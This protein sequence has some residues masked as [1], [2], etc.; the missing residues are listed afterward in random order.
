[1]IFVVDCCLIITS[2]MH[3]PRRKACRR[4]DR[5]NRL[6][7]PPIV[8]TSL[9]I[10]ALID[11]IVKS[12]NCIDFHEQ[13]RSRSVFFRCLSNHDVVHLKKEDEHHTGGV[14]R[15]RPAYCLTACYCAAGSISY[16]GL[17]CRHIPDIFPG[18]IIRHT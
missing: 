5:L 2:S 8:S 9:P 11:N 6:D 14:G 18:S 7:S 17:S 16:A 10:C 12:Y 13:I 4:V 15:S 1:M 3:V